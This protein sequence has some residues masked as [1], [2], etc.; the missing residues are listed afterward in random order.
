AGLD[1]DFDP[2]KCQLLV[3]PALLNASS[4]MSMAISSKVF[5]QH[6]I[7]PV[8]PAAY[9]HGTTADDFT[10]DPDDQQVGAIVNC[11]E[12]DFGG[13]NTDDG[14]QIPV[15]PLIEPD[16]LRIWVEDSS[17]LTSIRGLAQLMLSSTIIFSSSSTSPFGYDLSTKTVSLPRDPKPET[18]A[19]INFSQADAEELI[20]DSGSPLYV[21][22]YCNLV[23][24]EFAKWGNAMAKDLGSG[25]GLV[26][27][28][29]WLST[30]MSWTACED[31]T[32]TEVGLA[33]ALY[34]HAK[35]K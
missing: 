9:G 2:G 3:D 12:L 19:N 6:I 29:A 34:G 8:L 16:G 35:L 14:Q 24:G 26:D 27:I 5:L 17:V 13:L 18:T 30:A 7:A 28:S 21:Q 4:D 23:T 10:Y 32:F 20:K 1:D 22:A 31:W 33:D 11:E 25:I 15:K